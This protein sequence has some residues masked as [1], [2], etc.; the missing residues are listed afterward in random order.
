M[1]VINLWECEEGSE[2]AAQD[3]EVRAAR[4]A[5]SQSGTVTGPPEVQHYEVEDYRQSQGG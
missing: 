5:M 1:I 2:R 4:E 3:P